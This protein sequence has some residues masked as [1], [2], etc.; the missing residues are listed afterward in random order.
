METDSLLNG[1]PKGPVRT[2]AGQKDSGPWLIRAVR[3]N[4]IGHCLKISHE[5]EIDFEPL[6]ELML[7]F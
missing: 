5:I 7:F 6:L 4:S 1:S 2:E 3:V